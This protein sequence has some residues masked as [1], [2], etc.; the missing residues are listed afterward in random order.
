MIIKNLLDNAACYSPESSQIDVEI[1]ET[2]GHVRVLIQNRSDDLPDELDRL[3][4]PL[5]RKDSSRQ[6]EGS[7]LGIGLSLSLESAHAMGGK[8]LAQKT[9]DGLIGFSFI[10]PCG[11]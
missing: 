11:A 1:S 7:H 5:F 2:N 10:L 9:A 6:N 4:E 8:L 3:F